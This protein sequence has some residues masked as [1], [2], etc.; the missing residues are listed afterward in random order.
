MLRPLC[1]WGPLVQAGTPRPLLPQ[2]LLHPGERW[3][4]GF[5]LQDSALLL[6]LQPVPAA[7]LAP[8]VTVVCR[9]CLAAGSLLPAVAW[10]IQKAPLAHSF[11][12]FPLSTGL[13]LPS[14]TGSRPLGPSTPSAP[15]SS[16]SF[17]PRR[18]PLLSPTGSPLP[19][20][21]TLWALCMLFPW[22]RR[23]PCLLHRPGSFAAGNSQGGRHLPSRPPSPQSRKMLWA[24]TA[25]Q[26]SL[27]LSCCLSTSVSLSILLPLLVLSQLSVSSCFTV[28][29]G[30]KPGPSSG[31]Q[32]ITAS[33]EQPLCLAPIGSFLLTLPCREARLPP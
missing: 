17:P 11:R 19:L 23:P 27:S 30:M 5:S 16:V 13:N 2:P 33:P 7:S 18:S 28:R 29:T 22:P 14:W 4:R 24:S 12:D 9:T 20:E 15:A 3:T 25:H 21:H 31:S 32:T 8:A 26:L 1:C 10:S 6:P